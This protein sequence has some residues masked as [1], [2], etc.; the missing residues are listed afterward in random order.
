MV[1]Y[2]FKAKDGTEV[3]IREPVMTDAALLMAMINAV[4]EEPMSGIIF[5]KKTTLEDEKKWLKQRM[6][7]IERKKT[8]ILLAE[9]DG[10]AMG[11]CDVVRRQ[12]K[13]FHRA[14]LGIVIREELR[15]KGVGEALIKRTIALAK[16][17]MKGLEQVDLKTFTYNRRAQ[18]LYRKMGFRRTGCIPRAIKEGKKYYGEVEMVLYLR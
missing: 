9:V 10:E 4:I 1:R 3:L 18:S 17:R 8:V 14:E 15:G 7:D 11:N 6:R 12:F 5:N 13:E 2:S 16:Q